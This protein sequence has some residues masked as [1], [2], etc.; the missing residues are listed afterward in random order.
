MH[1]INRPRAVVDRRS[2]LAQLDE[3]AENGPPNRPQLVAFLKEALAA[4]RAEIRQRFDTDGSGTDAAHALCFLTDQ[5]IRVL[6]D[7]TVG[8]IY[9]AAN[10]TEGERMALVAVGGYGRGELAPYSDVDLLF[11]LSY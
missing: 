8:H 7:F 4:G 11:L 10:P 1:A 6:Y 5:L 2:L 3:L 9:P